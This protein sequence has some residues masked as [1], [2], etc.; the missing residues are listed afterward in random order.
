MEF[1][2]GSTPAFGLG[3]PYVIFKVKFTTS[4]IGLNYCANGHPVH[5]VVARLEAVRVLQGHR[6]GERSARIARS[7]PVTASLAH[8]EAI[9]VPI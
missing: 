2:I 8:A 7:A 1:L 5:Q 9:R 4:N 3:L 6:G